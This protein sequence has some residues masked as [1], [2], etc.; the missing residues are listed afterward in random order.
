MGFTTV[1]GFAARLA[2]DQLHRVERT[3]AAP[4]VSVIRDIYITH[5]WRKC[6]R[7]SERAFLLAAAPCVS[8]GAPQQP[9]HNNISHIVV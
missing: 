6:W 7:D 1:S 4:V 3:V 9:C 8:F 2:A 5:I